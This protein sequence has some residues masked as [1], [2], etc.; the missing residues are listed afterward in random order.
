MYRALPSNHPLADREV[1][2]WTD[3]RAERI[4]LTSIAL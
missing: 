3:L 4:L 1:V 2:H